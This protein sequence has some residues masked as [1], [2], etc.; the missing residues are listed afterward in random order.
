MT[1]L[2]A[3]RPPTAVL[4]QA[5]RPDCELVGYLEP[6]PYMGPGKALGLPAEMI[7]LGLWWSEGPAWDDHAESSRK[8][9]SVFAANDQ[10]LMQR[11]LAKKRHHHLVSAVGVSII[12]MPGQIA[13][14]M[15][16]SANA[17]C[18]PFEGSHSGKSSAIFGPRHVLAAVEGPKSVAVIRYS[19][20]SHSGFFN[21]TVCG[22]PADHFVDRAVQ[23]PSTVFLGMTSGD[24][25]DAW[26][27]TVVCIAID[28]AINALIDA[29][30]V[31]LF[32]LGGPVLFGL[33]E[34]L[35][36]RWL[37]PVAIA[38]VRGLIQPMIKKGTKA[39]IK[40]LIKQGIRA[41]HD[42][43][44]LRADPAD[45]DD[46]IADLWDEYVVSP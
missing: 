34:R 16:D 26:V 19:E 14:C 22:K 29:L 25:V 37:A 4:A 17:R 20:G 39:L 21:F 43:R 5:L 30:A 31:A 7:G 3:H 35:L 23:A 2:P 11:S 41:A 24:T 13:V 15:E 33:A 27:S 12:P 46:G 1:A 45:N 10:V 28:A 40:F 44:D 42:G 6:H 36:A 38:A 9:T 18:G 8:S 32:E